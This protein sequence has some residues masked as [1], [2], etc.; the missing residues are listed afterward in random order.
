MLV[1][2]E[3]APAPMGCPVCG[4]VAPA[5]GRTLVRLGRRSGDGP[6]RCGS[7]AARGDGAAP[8]LPARPSRFVEQDECVA[9]PRALLTRRACRWLI[10]QA[11]REHASVNRVRRQLGTGWRTP[12]EAIKPL[13]ANAADQEARFEGVS[14]LGVDE[15][16]W[17]HVSTKPIADGGRGPK[18]LTG[19]V[20]LTRHA[21]K[22]RNLV[23]RAR[24]LDLVPGRSGKAYADWLTQRGQGFRD[25]VQVG[26]GTPM[27]DIALLRAEPGLF[28][29]VA[30]DPTVSR[31]V[32]ALAAD[33]PAVL[34]AINTARAVARARAW[35]LARAHA[36]DHDTSA[37][38]PLIVDLD[39]TLVGSHSE[40]ECAAPTYKRGFGFH[41]LCA[42]VDHGAA[43]P[44]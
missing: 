7:C 15:H 13:L 17:H 29:P 1:T 19:M 37:Q 28:G 33:A 38:A 14:P 34:K 40:K 8:N 30:S 22:D 11:R 10:G 35:K 31:T 26:V 27:S 23:V 16:V 41:P 20:D 25:G 21:D 6:G 44:R 43:G 2:V 32:T 12:W 39:A 3:S 36:P 9:A 42:F 5:H 24:L 18:E 4:V